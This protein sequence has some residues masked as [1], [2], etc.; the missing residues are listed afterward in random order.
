MPARRRLRGH[1]RERL[2]REKRFALS[3]CGS[4]QENACV[5]PR[6]A[7]VTATPWSYAAGDVSG[8]LLYT[9]FADYRGRVAASL[10][11][12]AEW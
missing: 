9:H 5:P 7:T 11:L 10:F 8:P 3:A 2:R 12:R 6:Q 1:K 4:S